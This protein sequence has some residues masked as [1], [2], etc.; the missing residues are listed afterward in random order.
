MALDILKHLMRRT[1]RGPINPVDKA[2]IFS[3]FP[4]EIETDK[5]TITPSRYVIPAGTETN[6]SRLV[7]GPASWW[8]DVNP[9]EP[10]MEVTEN[11]LAIA[12]SVVND[13]VNSMIYTNPESRIGVF[14]TV[15]DVTIP[16]MKETMKAELANA[17]RRQRAWYQ[18]QVD[19]ADIGWARSN[20]NPLAISDDAR[21]AASE[22]K[23]SK[24]WQNPNYANVALIECVACGALRNPK[25]PICGSCKN[26][27]DLDLAKTLKLIA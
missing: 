7:I 3:I 10:L 22:L 20:Q 5:I 15:G 21:L 13:Y 24:P 4:R 16:Q 25:F 27:V 19:F 1:V 9:D 17:I 18:K 23:I 6:P 12:K 2:T 26:I 14:Y 8:R 11:A